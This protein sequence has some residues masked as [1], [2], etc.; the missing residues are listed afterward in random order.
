M[1]DACTALTIPNTI[2]PTTSIPTEPMATPMPIQAPELNSLLGA[3]VGCTVLDDAVVLVG[4]GGV[5]GAA[6]G[7]VGVVDG[8]VIAGKHVTTTAPPVATVHVA[9]GNATPETCELAAQSDCEKI[10][11]CV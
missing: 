11:H 4:C 3:G 10:A 1:R 9:G 2:A 6:V 5:V 7:E 8:V